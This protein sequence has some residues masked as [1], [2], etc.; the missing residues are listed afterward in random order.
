MSARYKLVEPIEVS[1]GSPMPSRFADRMAAARRRKMKIEILRHPTEED[2]RRC[3]FLAMT[4]IGR[5]NWSS[6]V[7]DEWKRK[8]LKAEHSP[9]RT[10]MFTI[11][12]EVPYWVSVHFCRHKFGVE[13]YVSSQRNDRQDKYDRNEAPQG[14]SVVHV[15]D[16]NAQELMQMARMRLCGQASSETRWVMARICSEVKRTNPEF[17]DFLKPKC[18]IHGGC[19]EFKSCGFYEMEAKNGQD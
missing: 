2:W 11:R 16:V 3:K 15:M 12:M 4:T 18:V 6:T 9:I 1:V 7:T 14:A 13:H 5:R 17:A 10:L 8:M 19:N